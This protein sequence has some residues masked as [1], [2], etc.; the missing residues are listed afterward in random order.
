M[1]FYRFQWRVVSHACQDASCKRSAVTHHLRLEPSLVTSDVLP[2]VLA[3]SCVDMPTIDSDNEGFGGL[4]QLCPTPAGHPS[5][6]NFCFKRISDENLRLTS[7]FSLLALLLSIGWSTPPHK[8]RYGRD[9]SFVTEG[10]SPSSTLL[11]PA[12][13][14][15]G[16]APPERRLLPERAARVPGH[17]DRS[18][19]VTR[20]SG[21]LAGAGETG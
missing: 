17:R 10:F 19:G 20:R 4:R 9:G 13:Q 6:S 8:R 2:A 5:P 1:L 15:G 3:L 14:Q 7:A 18:Q 16:S 12:M 21:P 11:A